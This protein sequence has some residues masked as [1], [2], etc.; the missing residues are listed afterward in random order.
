MGPRFQVQQLRDSL[1]WHSVNVASTTSQQP[2]YD[3]QLGVPGVTLR[4]VMW[5]SF[6]MRKLKMDV[7]S[8]TASMFAWP[9]KGNISTSVEAT[10][11]DQPGAVVVFEG[12]LAVFLP[13]QW[14]SKALCVPTFE[15]VAHRSLACSA[16]ICEFGVLGNFLRQPA[17]C[18]YPKSVKNL[19]EVLAFCS[20]F[21]LHGFQRCLQPDDVRFC[22]PAFVASTP[23]NPK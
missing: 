4:G 1:S 16:V 17:N 19:C 13:R 9:W 20:C 14:K 15:D 12:A 10:H 8:E 21:T 18:W 23:E 3:C 11:W 5:W 2:G 7:F 22:L 6:Q